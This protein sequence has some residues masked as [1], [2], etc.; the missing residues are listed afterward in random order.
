MK[1]CDEKMKMPR[2]WDILNRFKGVCDVHGWRTSESEDW[3]K[4]DDEYHSFL[5]TR[6]IH[7]SSF[8]RIVSNRKCIVREGLSYHVVD[9]SYTAWLF[10]EAP[11]EALVKTVFD[12]PNYSGR[13][14][15]YDFSLMLK[16]EKVCVKLNNTDSPVF[17]EFEHFLKDELK[18]KLKPLSSLSSVGINSTNHTIEEPA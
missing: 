6:G 3:I 16:G 4:I 11:S 7:L 5:L 18:V 13:I 9:A 15:L 8:R 2:V 17:Q 14:A 1:V 10:S 12:N